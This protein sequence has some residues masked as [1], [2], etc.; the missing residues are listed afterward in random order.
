MWRVI[1]FSIRSAFLLVMVGA[2]SN[3]PREPFT[4]DEQARAD[5]LGI[6]DARFLADAP[7]TAGEA[8][9]YAR[10]HF[11]RCFPCHAWCSGS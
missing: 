3:L 4:A 2:C 5:V 1:H 8:A 7:A 6:A 9:A 10:R 11:Q